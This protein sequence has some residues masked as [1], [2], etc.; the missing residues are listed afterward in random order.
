MRK[1]AVSEIYLNAPIQNSGFSP[2]ERVGKVVPIL[3]ADWVR[4]ESDAPLESIDLWNSACTGYPSKED[5]RTGLE[6]KYSSDV[7]G[8]LMQARPE[9]HLIK[10]DVDEDFELWTLEMLD[11]LIQKGSLRVENQKVYAC[12]RCGNTIALLDSM[13][14]AVCG[15]CMSRKV[16]VVD[17]KVI[18][19]SINA[20]ALERTSQATDGSFDAHSYPLHDT[21]VNKRRTMGVEL[22]QLGFEGEVLDPKI[23]VGMLALYVAQRYDY[24]SVELVASR[25]SAAHNLPQLFG[26]LGDGADDFP[27]LRMKQIVKAPVGYIQYLYEDGVL[28]KDAYHQVLREVLPPYLL[29]MKRDMSPETAERIIFGKHTI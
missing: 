29:R 18:I 20:E 25:G 10:T 19:S 7:L 8:S 17:K 21:I 24:D 28:S 26:F 6:E 22:D 11:T 27:Q 9:N 14:P 12:K 4:N 1:S 23:A 3:V 2:D 16:A 15:A 5:A 13:P